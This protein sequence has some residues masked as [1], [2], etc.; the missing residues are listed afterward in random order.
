MDIQYN[1][2][3]LIIARITKHVDEEPSTKK[4]Y[5]N[6]TGDFGFWGSTGTTRGIPNTSR[7][8]PILRRSSV[9][10]YKLLEAQPMSG[11]IDP[12]SLQTPPH[13]SAATSNRTWERRRS[14]HFASY[15][16]PGASHYTFRNS[17]YKCKPSLYCPPTL[18]HPSK[19]TDDHVDG[20]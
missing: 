13:L 1:G 5:R 8:T 15:V 20:K 9:I 6:E 19:A 3:L 18:L 14:H 16:Q 2:A 4:S 11:A 17:H 10:R 12:P 7:K